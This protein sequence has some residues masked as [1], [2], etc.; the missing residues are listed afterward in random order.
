MKEDN[1]SILSLSEDFEADK[2][3][4]LKE[5]EIVYKKLSVQNFKISAIHQEMIGIKIDVAKLLAKK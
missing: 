5:I 4:M 3:Y 2:V 1:Q